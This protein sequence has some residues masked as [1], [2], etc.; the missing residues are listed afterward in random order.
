M[1]SRYPGLAALLGNAVLLLAGCG[2]PTEPP[3]PPPPT[4]DLAVGE[5]AVVAGGAQLS[6]MTL[7]GGP[8]PREYVIAVQSS[9]RLASGNWPMSLSG[10]AVS[11]QAAATATKA[12]KTPT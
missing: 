2:G 5:S 12:R 10:A 3:P 7:E 11:A 8:G 1:S 4:L 9:G 6:E